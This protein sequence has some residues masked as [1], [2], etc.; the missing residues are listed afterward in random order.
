MDER[1]SNGKVDTGEKTV[2][3][4]SLRWATEMGMKI[5]SP[6]LDEFHEGVLHQSWR[7]EDKIL[8]GL[9][10]L[11][12]NTRKI[13]IKVYVCHSHSA[14]VYFCLSKAVDTFLYCF[15]LLSDYQEG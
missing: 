14:M 12:Q 13:N 3:K 1:N 10:E 11:L 8:S 9:G 6:I 4:D 7:L 5:T 15:S 2:K